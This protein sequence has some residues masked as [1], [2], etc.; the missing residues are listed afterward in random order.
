MSDELIYVRLI[1]VLL[2][3]IALHTDGV[4]IHNGECDEHL[5]QKARAVLLVRFSQPQL[6]I[7][8]VEIVRDMAVRHLLL[9]F[10]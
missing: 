7:E 9:L 1:Y 3:L 6:V 8:E 2:E 10:H 4:A 5:N